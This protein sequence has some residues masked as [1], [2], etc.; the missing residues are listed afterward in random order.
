M[1]SSGPWEGDR[2]AELLANGAGTQ[3]EARERWGKLWVRDKTP[4]Y[5]R[6][7]NSALRNGLAMPIG[8]ARGC[9]P[10]GSSLGER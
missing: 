4:G 3:H 6:G 8:L 2:Y 1:Q 5:C 10:L 9:L 7:A